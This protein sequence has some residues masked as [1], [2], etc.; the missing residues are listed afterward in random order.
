MHKLMIARVELL[1]ASHEDYDKLHK[2][3]KSIGFSREIPADGKLWELP[4]GTYFSDAFGL[5]YM[6]LRAVTTV[7]ETIA[8]KA[9]VIVTE[10]S[11]RSADFTLPE[12][13]QNKK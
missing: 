8:R 9:L 13:H 2:E 11:G 6:A 3:M 7:A 5:Q 1:D 12:I 10:W 4:S